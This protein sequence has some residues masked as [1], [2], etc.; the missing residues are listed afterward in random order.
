LVASGLPHIINPYI[1]GDMFDNL[2]FAKYPNKNTAD[3]AIELLRCKTLTYKEGRVWCNYDR[4]VHVR[5]PLQLL[6]KMKNMLASWG[7]QKR[8]IQIDEASCIMSV[9]EARIIKA[10]AKDGKL[11]IEWMDDEWK[12]WDELND[13]EEFQAMISKSRDDLAAAY[14]RQNL[15]LG[16]G[17]PTV[18]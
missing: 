6:Y 7:F 1:K 16:K 8:A 11:T 10:S 9:G 14:Q 15:G 3:E 18:A 12:Q 17:K 4:P 2:L 5:R 13:S